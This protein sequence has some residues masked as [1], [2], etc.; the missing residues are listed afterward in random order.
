MAAA[1]ASRRAAEAI[2]ST[3]EARG[4]RGAQ[5]ELARAAAWAPNPSN[6]P[7]YLDLPR[8][9]GEVVPAVAVKYAANSP[10]AMLDQYVPNLK[11]L[12]AIAL[13]IGLQDNL[14]GGN[15]LLVEGA[16]A[17]RDRPHVRDLRRRPRQS[18][19]ATSRGKGAAVLF[20]A[21]VVRAVRP[22][23]SDPA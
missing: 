4:N 11:K 12:K 2:K 6:P 7:L 23:P 8:K 15:R 18:H 13:D 16:D 19:S 1:A 20:E 5:G 21:A 17:L 10:V 3:E 14:I 9:N 22:G